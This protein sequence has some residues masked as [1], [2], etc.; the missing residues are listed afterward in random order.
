[1]PGHGNAEIVGRALEAG[2]HSVLPKPF[3]ASVLD[4][5][6]QKVLMRPLH[7][8]EEAGVLRP[9]AITETV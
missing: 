5:H 9:V 1:M 8:T 2:F 4:A 6:A 7:W 3:S